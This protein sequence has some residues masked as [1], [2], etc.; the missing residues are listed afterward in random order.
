MVH[1]VQTGLFFANWRQN[2]FLLYALQ[3][4]EM[5]NH[6]KDAGVS[7]HINILVWPKHLQFIA[8]HVLWQPATGRSHDSTHCLC[9]ASIAYCM[10]LHVCW[11]GPVSAS[12]VSTS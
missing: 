6:M 1:V 12:R 7:L 5:D 8:V 2:H 10:M 4:P 3:V 11:V 9:S